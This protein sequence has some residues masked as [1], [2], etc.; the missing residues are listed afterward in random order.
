MISIDGS[1]GEGGG[2]I[3][4]TAVSLSI[5][6]NIPVSITNIRENRSN[7]GIKPQHYTALSL[8]K[9]LSNATT[10]G[11]EIG[12]SHLSFKPGT[13]VSGRYQFD[14][15]TAGSLPLICQT[16]LPL[17]LHIAEPLEVSLR[18]GTDVKWSPSWDYFTQVFL[19][20]VQQCGLQVDTTLV[21]RGYYPK[22]GGDILLRIDP[23]HKLQGILYDKPAEY[24]IVNG[25]VHLGMLPDHVGKRMAH[26][27]IKGLLKED[28]Q[29]DISIDSQDTLS[30]GTGLTLWS[31]SDNGIVGCCVFGEMGVSAETVAQQAVSELINDISV[32]SSLD[33]HLFDQILMYLV[34]AKGQSVV[35]VRSLSSHARTTMCLLEKFYPEKTLF[36]MEQQN[37]LVHLK[38]QG[39]G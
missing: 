14:V 3:L 15:G 1:Y 37:D 8:L 5:L 27:A 32:G 30:P 36:S 39:I 22:G 13:F 38:I 11:L 17:A 7:P 28:L 29:A 18:G 23:C 35:L 9:Q 19:P 26:Q 12:S 24:H 20:L 4:R 10:E 25:K 6:T 31:R 34:L 21:R 33:E 2:Q 16:V